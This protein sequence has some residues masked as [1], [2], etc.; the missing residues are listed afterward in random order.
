MH[1]QL[2]LG[3]ESNSKRTRNKLQKNK[4]LHLFAWVNKNK[5]SKY[6]S[7]GV[8]VCMYINTS[9]FE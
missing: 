5:S 6:L 7:L 8:G 9:S 4:I 3:L 2:Y 1:N